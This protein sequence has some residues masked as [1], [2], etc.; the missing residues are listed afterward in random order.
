MYTGHWDMVQGHLRETVISGEAR[1]FVSCSQVGIWKIAWNF[2]C[3]QE[4]EL[5]NHEKHF[6][7]KPRP[8]REMP[9]NYVAVVY[10]QILEI[11]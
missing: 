4:Y 8:I 2:V 6:W 10:V 3:C 5:F 1:S 9:T 11:R 7:K